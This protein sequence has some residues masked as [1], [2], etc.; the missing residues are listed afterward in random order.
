[1]FIFF[2]IAIV[3]VYVNPEYSGKHPVKTIV[4]IQGSLNDVPF[5]S[6]SVC[7]EKEE[8]AP[9]ISE[10]IVSFFKDDCD[11]EE[12]D[13]DCDQNLLDQLKS[14]NKSIHMQDSVANF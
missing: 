6:V 2:I 9:T 3:L 5:P 14:M 13:M 8:N 1:M 7:D 12:S 4:K 10:T 11:E